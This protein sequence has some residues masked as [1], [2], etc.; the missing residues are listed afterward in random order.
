MTRVWN[1]CCSMKTWQAKQIR[2]AFLVA[3]VSPGNSKFMGV[4]FLHEMSGCMKNTFLCYRQT[5]PI[6]LCTSMPSQLP[7]GLVCNGFLTD[8]QGSTCWKRFVKSLCKHAH[9]DGKFTN[10][11]L[12]ASCATG[13]FHASVDEQVIKSFM[14]HRS[15]AVH[16]YKRLSNTL[17]KSANKT[18]STKSEKYQRLNWVAPQFDIDKVELSPD[19]VEESL[20]FSLRLATRCTITCAQCNWPLA[21]EEICAHCCARLT[22]IIHWRRRKSSCA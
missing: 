2:G 10:H 8:P 20:F 14:G 13:M 9:I 22:K 3:S 19:S 6:A 11:S 16:N 18:V 15:D 21:S 4:M 7:R 17:F 1:S 12:R 5:L